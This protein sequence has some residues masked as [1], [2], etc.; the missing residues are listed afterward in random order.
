[1]ELKLQSKASDLLNHERSA[2][3]PALES[4][5]SVK[6]PNPEISDPLKEKDAPRVNSVKKQVK[7]ESLGK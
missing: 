2:L 6:Q 1:M 4:K 7:L 3:N 5:Q